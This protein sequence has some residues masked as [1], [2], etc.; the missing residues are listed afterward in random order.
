MSLGASASLLGFVAKALAPDPARR[1]A[2]ANEMA[3][4]LQELVTEG[5]DIASADDLAAQVAAAVQ[6]EGAGDRPVLVLGAPRDSLRAGT[7]LSRGTHRAEFTMTLPGA[8]T[9]RTPL[10][11]R[12][13][14][15]RVLRAALAMLLGVA[16]W[17]LLRPSGGAPG[18]PAPR[19]ASAPA[20][21]QPDRAPPPLE[22]HDA[23]SPLVEHEEPPTHASGHATRAR[24]RARPS[25]ATLTPETAPG[26]RGQLHVFATHGWLLRG[27]PEEVQAPG[28]YEWPCGS[29][30]LS[31]VSRLDSRIVRQLSTRVRATGVSVI[32]LRAAASP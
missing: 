26:C 30:Q 6:E 1:F 8:P 32:D 23:E 24:S 4:A 2:D 13:P 5:A 14:R 16:V 22:R 10:L 15:L 28:R 7:E 25:A 17:L 27:G 18:R 31:A 11:A 3:R 29:Y 21:V 12:L 9:P 19:V 20:Y